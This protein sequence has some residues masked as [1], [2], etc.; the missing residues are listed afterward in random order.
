MRNPLALGAWR[1]VVA[2][3]GLVGF[4]FA[5]ATFYD[6]WPALSQQASLLTGVV[7]LALAFAGDR[8]VRVVSWFRGALAVLLLLVCV[9]YLTVIGGDLDTVGSLFEHL[10]TPLV[11]LADW[12]L[13]GRARVV[14]R[15]WYPLSWGLFPLLYLLYFLLADVQLYRGFL[16]PEAGDFGVT[17]GLFLVAVVATGYLLC[18]VV[19]PPRTEVVAR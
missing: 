5:L 14:V 17:V 13:V 1:L 10:V 8:A 18:G 15:W 9:T 12:V 19:R 7:Y 4:G 6:P 11:V 16:N 2:A 3:C